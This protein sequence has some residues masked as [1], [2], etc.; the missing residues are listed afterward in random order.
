VLLGRTPMHIRGTKDFKVTVTATTN[1]IAGG[2]INVYGRYV[3]EHETF[4]PSG[5]PQ[6]GSTYLNR[7]S[8]YFWFYSETGTVADESLFPAVSN[9]NL[10]QLAR[11]KGVYFSGVPSNQG[12][13]VALSAPDALTRPLAP[14]FMAAYSAASFHNATDELDIPVITSKSSVPAGTMAGLSFG[15]GGFA[16]TSLAQLCWGTLEPVTEVRHGER[17][18]AGV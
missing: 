4:E 14:V 2:K 8:K 6:G 3:P 5:V 12:C 11:V 17:K 13:A 9:D 10:G 7:S 16:F 15:R 18:Y 1:L